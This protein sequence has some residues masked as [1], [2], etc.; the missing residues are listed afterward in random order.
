[1]TGFRIPHRVLKY[2]GRPFTVNEIIEGVRRALQD[3]EERIVMISSEAREVIPW[4]TR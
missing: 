3:N 2:D 4:P 1:M